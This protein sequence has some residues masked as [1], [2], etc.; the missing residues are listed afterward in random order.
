MIDFEITEAADKDGYR[1]RNDVSKD[2]CK[3]RVEYE[4]RYANLTL[5]TD[6]LLM[7]GLKL[8][9]LL[10]HELQLQLLPKY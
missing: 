1:K 9:P 7:V 10:K 8:D 6:E 3:S 2:R 5:I 4:T